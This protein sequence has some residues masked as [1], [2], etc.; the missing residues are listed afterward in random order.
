MRQPGKIWGGQVFHEK[1]KYDSAA[2]VATAVPGLS[3]DYTNAD[4][5]DKTKVVLG[6]EADEEWQT[7]DAGDFRKTPTRAPVP[8]IAHDGY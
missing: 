2:L 6:A 7:W 5:L 3:Y 4:Y 1:R 8:I